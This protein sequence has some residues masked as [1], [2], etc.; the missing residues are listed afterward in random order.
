MNGVD[1]PSFEN[2]WL[3]YHRDILYG[4]LVPV[5]RDLEI[6]ERSSQRRKY[7]AIWYGHARP[8][9]RRTFSLTIQARALRVY[10]DSNVLTL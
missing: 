8:S 2:A 6:S 1:A 7:G 4:F 5:I 9:H 10:V 3:T